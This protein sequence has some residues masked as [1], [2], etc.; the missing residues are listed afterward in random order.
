MIKEITVPA[1]DN[2]NK[3]IVSILEYFVLCVPATYGVAFSD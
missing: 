1:F 2:V 3:D